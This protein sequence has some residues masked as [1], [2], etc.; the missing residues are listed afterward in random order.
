[1]TQADVTCDIISRTLHNTISFPL[2]VIIHTNF[3]QYDI[4]HIEHVR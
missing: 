1:M 3:T 4:T 2:I